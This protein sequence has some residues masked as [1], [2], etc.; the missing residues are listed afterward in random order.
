MKER[1]FGGFWINGPQHC[2]VRFLAFWARR[3]DPWLYKDW[4]LYF[5]TRFLVQQG[6]IL[7]LKVVI[8]SYLWTGFF[9]PV[10][11]VNYAK[12]IHVKW[13]CMLHLQSIFNWI[14]M[15]HDADDLA[16]CEDV[17]SW[18]SFLFIHFFIL[19]IPNKVKFR[20]LAFHILGFLT[21]ASFI[22]I[23]LLLK[24]F[25]LL[26]GFHFISIFHARVKAFFHLV[27]GHCIILL[28][29]FILHG[30]CALMRVPCIRSYW[31]RF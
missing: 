4:S 10:L 18:Y 5:K 7:E 30:N 12:N 6:S 8:F 22:R 29:F 14:L 17:C 9:T 20:P 16:L 27:W 11:G 3:V 19:S 2:L 24:F 15:N 21:P 23:I 13:L 31:S 1:E 28:Q 25:V 26:E